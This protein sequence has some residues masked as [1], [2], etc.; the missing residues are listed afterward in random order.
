MIGNSPKKSAQTE[1][2]TK[3]AAM[4]QGI[5]NPARFITGIPFGLSLSKPEVAHPSTSSGRTVFKGRVNSVR[6][7]R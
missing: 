2:A 4:L 6:S 5:I 1:L 7:S 3:V